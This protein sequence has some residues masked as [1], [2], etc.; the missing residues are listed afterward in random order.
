MG[1]GIF[2]AAGVFVL[3]LLISIPSSLV[4]LVAASFVMMRFGKDLKIDPTYQQRLTDGKI[5]PPQR[6]GGR[7][8]SEDELP[9]T[10]KISA[11]IFLL[12]GLFVMLVALVPLLDPTLATGESG[13][14]E[15]LGMTEAIQLT[16]LTVALLI[17]LICRVKVRAII[18]QT[19]F[20]SGII[21]I[22]AVAV[23]LLIAR[24]AGIGL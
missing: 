16:M 14:T 5:K 1:L 21:A 10:A 13:T 20:S 24:I 12:G 6:E 11:L 9:R 7:T 22:V 8:T 2:G 23:G 18:T 3:V 17:L 19:T 4:A 15:Q